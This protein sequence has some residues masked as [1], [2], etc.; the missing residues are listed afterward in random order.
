MKIAAVVQ[1]SILKSAICLAHNSAMKYRLKVLIEILGFFAL[2]F[3]M[4][5]HRLRDWLNR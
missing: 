3:G 2:P 1:G 4:S 5:A